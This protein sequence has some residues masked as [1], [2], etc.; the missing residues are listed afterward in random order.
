MFGGLLVIALAAALLIWQ[1]WAGQGASAPQKTPAESSTTQTPAQSTDTTPAGEE[2]GGEAAGGETSGEEVPGEDASGGEASGEDV[3]AEEQQDDDAATDEISACGTA[4]VT[5][6][7]M[8]DK[9]TYGADER[10]QMTLSLTNN[11]GVDCTIDVGTS[12]Q[13]FAITSGADTWW[14]STDCQANPTTQIVTLSAG[15][16]VSSQAPLV[17]DRTRSSVSTCDDE[18]RPRASGGGASYHLTVSIASFQSQG[19]A[20]FMLY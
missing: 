6:A 19:T 9:E 2:A 16:T 12:V 18:S 17:W 1:P 10:P 3:T 4:D 14:R 11:T 5:V 15:Q 13:A 8:T 7:A 20:Q